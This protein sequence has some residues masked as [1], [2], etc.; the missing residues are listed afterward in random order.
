MSCDAL[1]CGQ[2]HYLHDDFA[3]VRLTRE[4]IDQLP[5]LLGQNSSLRRVSRRMFKEQ[6]L[7]PLADDQT[8]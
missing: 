5:V 8:R 3:A 4:V 1:H 7:T 6:L 2:R